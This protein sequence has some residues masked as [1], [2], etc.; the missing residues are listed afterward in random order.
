MP[1]SPSSPSF[2][3]KSYEEPFDPAL[4]KA[5]LEEET[6][7]HQASVEAETKRTELRLKED[8]LR[9]ERRSDTLRGAGVIL[10]ILTVLFGIGFGIWLANRGP[11]GRTPEYVREERCIAEGGGWVPSGLLSQTSQGLCVNPGE[12]AR[13]PDDN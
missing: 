12:R 5:R 2:D 1:S 11:N 8:R 10:A 7:R 13:V 4:V 9:R 6:K 3:W